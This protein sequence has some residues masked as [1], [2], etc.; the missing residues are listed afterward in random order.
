VLHFW[1]AYDFIGLP[2]SAVR[3]K[4][5]SVPESCLNFESGRLGL[6]VTV[7]VD[8]GWEWRA[9]GVVHDDYEGIAV[10]TAGFAAPVAVAHALV[11]GQSK[12]I[13]VRI[14]GITHSED[15]LAFE[16][17]GPVATSTA[18]FHHVVELFASLI[19]CCGD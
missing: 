6:F 19:D 13:C 11:A 2:E 12:E 8:G 14:V 4:V 9:Y 3:A 10:V 17:I 15:R 16:L 1:Q 7:C 5:E 18:A